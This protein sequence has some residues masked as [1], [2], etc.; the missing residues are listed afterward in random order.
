MKRE[1]ETERERDKGHW[2]ALVTHPGCYAVVRA[3]VCPFSML[4]V[5]NYIAQTQCQ[6]FGTHIHPDV[7]FTCFLF[8][9]MHVFLVQNTKCQAFI[10]MKVECLV[11]VL[12]MK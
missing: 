12:E 10:P 4:K 11:A 5:I 9:I 6:V 3:V 1:R 8:K 7:G 2:R